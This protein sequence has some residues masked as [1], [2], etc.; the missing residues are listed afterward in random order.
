MD[1]VSSDDEGEENLRVFENTIWSSFVPNAKLV[2]GMPPS[3]LTP[4]SIPDHDAIYE[5]DLKDK[6]DIS[7]LELEFLVDEVSLNDDAY[8]T[9]H[10]LNLSA[11]KSWKEWRQ[12]I[13]REARDVMNESLLASS[14]YINGE[15]A[16][17]KLFLWK[18]KHALQRSALSTLNIIY[19]MYGPA[20]HGFSRL[21]AK[22]EKPGY[23]VLVTRYEKIN[24]TNL[25]LRTGLGKYSHNNNYD[26]IL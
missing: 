20:M 2:F 26:Y 23:Y 9:S 21:K 24:C 1:L 25:Y 11:T 4:G 13:F 14:E 5:F 22:E 12:N 19:E 16:A 8:D 10:Y 17:D 3:S 18:E 7:D 6:S 15:A